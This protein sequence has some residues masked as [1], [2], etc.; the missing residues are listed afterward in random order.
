M[1]RK[2]NK[3]PCVD[4]NF[5]H[6]VYHGSI[7]SDKNFDNAEL[8]AEAF[9]DMITFGRIKKLQEIPDSVKFA[10]CSLVDVVAKFVES[11]KNDLLSE[12]NDGYSITY[13]S[14]AKSTECAQ[15]MHMKARR[16]LSNTGLLYRGWS[17]KY[18]AQR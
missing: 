3:E 18:D 17:E 14:A 11:Q 4:Y 6:E 9:V 5:Y 15:E 13:A 2:N 8:E 16:W 10:I 12:S 1:I 7:A